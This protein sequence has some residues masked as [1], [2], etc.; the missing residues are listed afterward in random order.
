MKRSSSFSVSRAVL[1]PP[2]DLE[3]FAVDDSLVLLSWGSSR[4]SRQF[5]L[6]AAEKAVFDLLCAGHTNGEIAALRRR[7]SKT[8]AHQVQ[9]IFTKLGVSSRAELFARSSREH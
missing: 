1:D 2:G 7:S 6:T 8:I 4:P 9:S 3:A 5:A